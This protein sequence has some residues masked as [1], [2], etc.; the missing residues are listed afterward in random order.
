VIVHRFFIAE[1]CDEN[2]HVGK[3]A[4]KPA[5]RIPN[6]SGRGVRDVTNT[7]EFDTVRA[8]GNNW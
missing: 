7:H 1:Q 3:P 4:S 5:D 8:A 2:G 6:L